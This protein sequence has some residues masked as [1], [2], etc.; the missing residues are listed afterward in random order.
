MRVAMATLVALLILNFVDEQF[1]DARYTQ[2][3]TSILS[4]IARSFG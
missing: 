1:N 4:Q 3:A 2:A